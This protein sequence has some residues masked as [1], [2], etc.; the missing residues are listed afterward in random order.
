LMCIISAGKDFKDGKF[1]WYTHED[2]YSS[3]VYN[4]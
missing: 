3:H 2:L 4:F 1:T